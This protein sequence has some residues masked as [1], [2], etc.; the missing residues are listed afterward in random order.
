MPKRSPSFSCS[1]AA[2]GQARRL[3]GRA[4]IA[5]VAARATA[6]A[7]PVTTTPG[8]AARPTRRA[9]GRRTPTRTA[10]A[11]RTRTTAAPR[12]PT[13]TAA[14]R[15][16]RYGSGRLPHVSFG[17]DRLPSAGLPGLSD[18]SGLSPAGRGAVLLVGCYGCAAAA[19]A[20]VGMAVGAAARRPTRRRRRRARTAP[21]SRRAASSTA[22]ATGAA[23]SAGVA[24]GAS[25]ARWRP[26]VGTYVDGRQLRG[27]AGGLD[28]D[29]QERRDL[30]SE[31]QHLVPAGVRRERRLLQGR[32]A[33]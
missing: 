11:R 28:D 3:A 18:L 19:G 29:R 23:Y 13:C 33:P 22:A 6:V 1:R 2:R 15:T 31:R 4:P 9:R 26:A 17:C 8:A 12:T 7:R 14:A 32:A 30:L 27:T 5:T 21:V 24:T 16:A 25:G 20:I 10:A